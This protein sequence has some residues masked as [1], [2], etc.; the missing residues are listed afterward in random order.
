MGVSNTHSRYDIMKPEWQKCRDA[1]AGERAVHTAGETYLPR[2]VDEEDDAY[3]LRLNM[4]PFFNATWRTINGL[5]GIMFRKP[6]RVEASNT[7]LDVMKNIDMSGTDMDSFAQEVAEEALTIGRVGLLADYSRVEIPNATQADVQQLGL[8][9]FVALYKAEAIINWRVS[10]VNGVKVLSQVVLTEEVE[11]P[12]EDEFDYR[13]ETQ[14]RVLDLSEGKYRQRTF[15]I[16]DDNDDELLTEVFPLLG[17][18]P[19]DF[20][21]FVFIG[22]DAV[23]P[24]V[25]DP[26][27]IDLISTNFKHY[28]QATSYERGCF[29]SGLPTMFV[30]GYDDQGPEDK[31]IY[32][33][34]NVANSLPNP[35]AK[36]YYV[37]IQGNFDALRTNLED[38][39]NEMAV[40]GARMLETQK[41]GV[42]AAET[43]GRRQVGEESMLSAMAQT[44]SQG[45]TQVLRW[46][47]LWQG[48]TEEPVYE[49]NR[50]FMSVKMDAPTLLAMVSSWQQGAISKETL[51]DNMKQGQI[52]KDD[53]T[54]EEEESRI[55][56]QLIGTNSALTGDV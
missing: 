28:G 13:C 17:N 55:N 10:S 1:S 43:V 41:S 22:T 7:L 3:A 18:A 31:K 51:F 11:I 8:R 5:R 45:L 29:F 40:L 42:E 30:S 46:V 20:I 2:L 36:A 37:E 6:P 33:G 35:Q 15:R 26:P 4:T 44:I 48:V 56:N 16:N 32:I 19:L 21:P 12:G 50:D 34:G 9:A 23:T 38:K 47:A 39:K 24:D 49:I 27:L 54:F 52:I 53:V 25:D 14:Y